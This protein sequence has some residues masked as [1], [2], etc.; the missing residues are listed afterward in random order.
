MVTLR[1]ATR[2]DEPH[3]LALT[4]RLAAFP[5][6]P[7]RDA[8]QIAQADQPMLSAA[9][10]EAPADTLVL[11]ATTEDGRVT[12]CV[13]VTTRLDFFTGRPH[14]HVE[15]LAVAPEAEGRGVGRALMRGAEDWARAR[16]LDHLTL[17]VF[18]TNTRAR[19]LYEKLGYQ[20]ELVKY[21][22]AIP[23]VPCHEG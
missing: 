10:R 1:N 20:A 15:V 23:E 6:P 22:K 8:G 9:V 3:L 5:V 14:G 21:R 19:G 13:L 4:S 2:S 16:G 7:W 17:N 11:V 18:D 12:G